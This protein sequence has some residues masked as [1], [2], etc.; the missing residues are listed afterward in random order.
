MRLANVAKVTLVTLTLALGA[1]AEAP[2]QEADAARQAMN[3]AEAAQASMYA[4]QEWDDAQAALRAVD[5]EM[6]AQAGKLALTR[7]YERTNELIADAKIKAM[8][9]QEAAVEGKAQAK[10]D[11]ETA[12][13]TVR[14]GIAGIQTLM[15]DLSA[16]PQKAKG[17]EADMT[18]LQG[19]VD[20]LT[21]QVPTLEAA[22][23]EEDFED[24]VTQ[25]E[26]VQGQIDVL[27]QDLAAA[28]EK[29]GCAPAAAP[30]A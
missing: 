2:V 3:D 22:I 23:A 19:S 9:A 17:F 29:M 4:S 15:V 20:G 25:A 13:A 12:L 18:V 21:A 6:A 1:C 7:S 11:A 26:S 10:S 28:Q 14:D 24:A 5:E 8:A 27:H 30:I 16:C